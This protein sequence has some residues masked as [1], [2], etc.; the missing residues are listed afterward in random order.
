MTL[1]VIQEQAICARERAAGPL[2]VLHL[3]DERSFRGGERQ[4]L[5]LARYLRAQGHSNVVVCRAGAPLEEAAH[6]EGFE[7]LTLP[8]LGEWDLVSAW[9]LRRAALARPRPV[10]H[11]HT[12]HTAGLAFWASLRSPMIRVAHRRV[13]FATTSGLSFRLKYGS[14]DAVIA[15]SEAVRSVLLRGGRAGEAR[16]SLVRSAVDLGDVPPRDEGSRARVAARL[17]LP[18]RTLWVG[19]LAALVAH[20][21]HRTLL[22]AMALMSARVPEAT[23]I[24]AGEGPLRGELE[25]LRDELCLGARVRFAGFVRE[26]YELLGALDLFALSS[27]EEG[28]GSALLEAMAMGLPVAATAAGGIPEA[29]EH[30]RTG[31]LSPVGDAAALSASMERLLRDRRLAASLGE[32]GRARVRGFSAE[33]MGRRIESVYFSALARRGLSLPA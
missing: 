11:A 3:D 32:A 29:V 27:K 8:F 7:I 18:P 24:L 20:K 23:L 33:T 6:R 22:R 14:A 10:L 2:T 12:A 25:R 17:G 5:Y 15:I 4:L 31:L 28:M 16:V 9:A 26:R 19:C 30:G 21:D 1:A 13:D